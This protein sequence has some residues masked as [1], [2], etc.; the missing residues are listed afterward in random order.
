MLFDLKEAFTSVTKENGFR[1]KLFI[2]TFLVMLAN[3]LTTFSFRHNT[4]IPGKLILNPQTPFVFMNLIAGFVVLFVVLCYL[5]SFLHNKIN[6][7]EMPEWTEVY[8]YF[9]KGFKLA[10]SNIILG[11][12]AFILNILLIYIAYY[13]YSVSS[14]AGESLLGNFFHILI[15]V[16]WFAFVFVSILQTAIFAKKLKFRDFFNFVKGYYSLAGNFVNFLVFSAVVFGVMT[17]WVWLSFV[18]KTSGDFSYL[19]I[20]LLSAPVFYFM[21]V[22]V[23][24]LAQW[25]KKSY[26]ADEIE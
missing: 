24:L 12:P 15:F 3:F 20:L 10:I 7:K 14:E 16:G 6:N 21:T 13:L 8:K 17:L 23:D 4:Y 1:E 26:S 25:A 11:I 2:G 5:L 19:L 18:A 9:I 22:Y